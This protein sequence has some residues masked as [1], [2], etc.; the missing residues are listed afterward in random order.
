MGTINDRNSKGT[1]KQKRIRSGDEYTE[2]LYKKCLNDMGNHYGVVTHLELNILKYEV[3]WALGSITIKLVEVTEFQLSY[4]KSQE[5]ILLKCCTQCISRF[6]KLSSG[7]RTG[8]VQFSFQSQR[9]TM[10]KNVPTT[11]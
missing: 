6:G 11:V 7:L 10:A 1:I 8:K 5:L 9:R 4:L 2:E 3:K